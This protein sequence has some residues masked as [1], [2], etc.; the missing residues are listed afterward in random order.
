M[1]DVRRVRVA[2][3]IREGVVLAVVG[4]PL[5]DRP[6]HRHAAEHAEHG[7]HGRVSGEAAVSE[8]AVEADRRAER[9]DDVQRDE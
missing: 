2:R 8:I 5:R 4:D 6:L 1:T 9:A 3:L 7:F